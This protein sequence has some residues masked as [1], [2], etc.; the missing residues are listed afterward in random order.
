MKRL[1]FLTLVI[2]FIASCSDNPVQKIGET[3]CTIVT[4]TEAKYAT[5]DTVN[6]YEIDLVYPV[7]DGDFSSEVLNNINN[8]ISE[9]FNLFLNK[10]EFIGAHQDLPEDMSSNNGEWSGLLNNTYGITQ[11]DS[12]IT[13]WFSIYQYYLG[14]AHGFTVNKTLHFNLNTG[15]SLTLQDVF[16]TDAN[17]VESIQNIIN[18]NLPDSLC[19]GIETDSSTLAMID[20]FIFTD[21]SIILKIDDYALC[22]Y[23]F[24]LNTISY[25][26]SDF[27]DI[28]KLPDFV[29]C[30][31]IS[32]AQNE[33]EIAT[34]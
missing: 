9:K 10:S 19:W 11:C 5:I 15:N 33:G 12:V 31:D 20:N 7:I 18:A 34:H 29:N 26:K 4:A 17:S 30:Q 3:T 23:A 27:K 2:F 32:V 8:T 21:D 24:G 1:F 25:A 13:I 14:A 22:P 28:L 6:H 16:K